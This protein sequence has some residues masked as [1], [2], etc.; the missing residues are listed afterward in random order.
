MRWS[1]G[2]RIGAACLFAGAGGGC[3]RS[4]PNGAAPSSEVA[5][6]A[7][8]TS[9]DDRAAAKAIATLGPVLKPGFVSGVHVRF[10]VQSDADVHA[11]SPLIY[12]INHDLRTIVAQR[13]GIL[14][15]GGNRWTAYNWENNASNAGSD[16]LFQNDAA[17]GET[18]SPAAP[19]LEAID[20]ASSVG[21]PTIITLSNVDYVSADKGPGG[22]VR[23]SGADYLS[24][25]FKKNLPRK[26]TRF[27]DLPDPTDDSVYQDELVA[28][29]RRVRPNAALLFSMDNEPD[30]WAHTHAEV[31]PKPV[32]YADLWRRNHDFAAAAKDAWPA[33]PVLGFVSY[34]FTGFT[35]LQDAPDANGRDFTDWY[36]DQARQAEKAE[37]RRLIDYLDVHWYPEAQAAGQR[38]VTESTDPPVVALRE[39]A[40]RSLWDPTY[41]EPSWIHDKVGGPIKL[42]PWLRA[43]IDAHYPGTKLAITEWNYGGGGHISGAIAVADVLGTLGRLGVDLATYWPLFAHEEYALA[44]FRIFRNYDGLGAHFGDTSVA[45]SSSDTSTATVYASVD[46]TDPK[47]TIVVAINK[48]NEPK[49]AGLQIAHS[50]VYVRARTYTLSAAAPT[51]AEGPALEPAATNAFLVPLPAQ[52]VSII[53]PEE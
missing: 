27:A 25:R 45:A 16:Y 8:T 36:L 24:K 50:A 34:G 13:M 6:S 19:I 32:S 21:A 12:G 47:R 31:Y 33:A 44:A 5:P 3:R 30:L 40:P 14:R 17:L 43:K 53:V 10:E 38:I 15:V 7:R 42:V 22:D 29:L 39:Q 46:R 37:G 20:V 48:A 28:Y 35:T 26:P 52:S 49:N 23:G 2:I 9:N 18:D 11:I 4:A 1:T 51:I 41:Q